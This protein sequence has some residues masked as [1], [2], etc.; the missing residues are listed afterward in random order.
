M[1][2]LFDSLYSSLQKFEGFS[3]VYFFCM[4]TNENIDILFETYWPSV[5]ARSPAC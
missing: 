4:D 3:N 2:G 5:E 1:Y